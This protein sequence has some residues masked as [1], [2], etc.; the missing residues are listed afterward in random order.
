MLADFHN[1]SRKTVK[2]LKTIKARAISYRVDLK[3][4][5]T[6]NAIQSDDEN[7]NFM[8]DESQILR[9]SVWN[10]GMIEQMNIP[11]RGESEKE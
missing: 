4:G 3:R 2:T 1:S 6:I 10:E 5:S 11:L 7:D 8:T 9:S